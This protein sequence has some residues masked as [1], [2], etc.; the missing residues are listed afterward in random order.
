MK[1]LSDNVAS[2][3]DS[4]CSKQSQS[5]GGRA[6]EGWQQEGGCIWTA[7]AG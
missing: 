6:G 7:G 1:K 3:L 5:E 2:C 4:P